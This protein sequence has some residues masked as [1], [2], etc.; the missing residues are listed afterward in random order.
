MPQPTLLRHQ[1]TATTFVP[2]F[3][4]AISERTL[5]TGIGRIINMPV[6]DAENTSV[7]LSNAGEESVLISFGMTTPKPFANE[8]GSSEVVVPPG[9]KF[10]LTGPAFPAAG[11]AATACISSRH[12]S[13]VVTIQRGSISSMELFQ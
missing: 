8:Y 9:T 10:L 4:A 2:C 3:G 11:A 6:M 1:S 5:G 13:S 12:A 7:T